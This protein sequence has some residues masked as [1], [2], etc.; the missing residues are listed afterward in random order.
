MSLKP[1][2]KTTPDEYKFI[3]EASPIA[4]EFAK[5]VDANTLEAETIVKLFNLVRH[6]S[7]FID[8]HVRKDA[9]EYHFQADWIGRLARLEKLS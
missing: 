9:Q 3:S 4:L 2:S 1:E 7:K 8:I 6:G 5:L